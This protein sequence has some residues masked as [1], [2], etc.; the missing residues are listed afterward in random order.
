MHGTRK[1][2]ETIE[3]CIFGKYGA[4]RELVTICHVRTPKE[5]RRGSDP[6]PTCQY[7]MSRR[8]N[9]PGRTHKHLTRAW[10]R[11]ARAGTPRAVHRATMWTC[12][13]CSSTRRS[14]HR[15]EERRLNKIREA[16][17]S[18]VARGR[19]GEEDAAHLWNWYV[20]ETREWNAEMRT[21]TPSQRTDPRP[22]GGCQKQSPPQSLSLPLPP[23]PVRV[24]SRPRSLV[25]D[26]L[27]S[28]NL[29]TRSG[30]P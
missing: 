25:P 28:P 11:R 9:P 6:L 18:V 22:R 26:R 8:T 29:A 3:F 14:T 24:S 17:A 5:G 12:P 30:S 27:A 10:L 1:V 13:M 2:I 4:R 21:A 16:V 7:P 23:R 20:L 19:G 15:N